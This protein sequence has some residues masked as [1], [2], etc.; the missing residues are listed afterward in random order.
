MAFNPQGCKANGGFKGSKTQYKMMKKGMHSKRG[1]F[2]GMIMKLDL[3]VK[4]R[5]QIKEIIM[6]SVKKMSYPS[7]AFT[8]GSFNKEK[9][10][11]LAKEKRDGKIQRRSDLMA[12]VYKVLNSSQ[13]KDL[14]TMMDMK[15]LRMKKMIQIR[16]SQNPLMPP[17]GAM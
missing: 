16:L 7:E 14:K 13:K 8:D 12:K 6:A 2:V 10:V 5:T 15:K 17:M 1:G 3:S 4:Q 11:K 9:F